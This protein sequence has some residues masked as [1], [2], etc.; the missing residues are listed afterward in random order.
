MIQAAKIHFEYFKGIVGSIWEDHLSYARRLMAVKVSAPY[1]A[2]A[3][4]ARIQSH[5]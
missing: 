5:A 4:K 2:T 1:T 3:I